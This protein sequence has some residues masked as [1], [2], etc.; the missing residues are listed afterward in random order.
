MEAGDF[1]RRNAINPPGYGILGHDCNAEEVE[2]VRRY[3]SQDP[4]NRFELLS[5]EEIQKRKKKVIEDFERG[6]K[7]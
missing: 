2:L 1:V 7:I 3:L 4:Q 5:D 6:D